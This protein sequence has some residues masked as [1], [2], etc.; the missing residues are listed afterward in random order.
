MAIQ[1]YSEMEADVFREGA[2][3]RLGHGDQLMMVIIDFNDGPQSAPEPPHS[4]PHEQIS[5]VA[6]GEIFFVLEDKCERLS[7]GDMFLVPANKPHSIQLLTKHVR[8]VDCFHPIRQD[9]LK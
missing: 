1:R 7:P 4:H 3:R 6:D 2:E 9:L 5:Y 8:L